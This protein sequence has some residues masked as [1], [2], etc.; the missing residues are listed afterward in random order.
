MPD[1][2][3][4]KIHDQSVRHQDHKILW[5]FREFLK[6]QK[7]W[8]FGNRWERPQYLVLSWRKTGRYVCV[9]ALDTGIGIPEKRLSPASAGCVLDTSRFIVV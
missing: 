1:V 8:F 9:K 4:H 3:T 2:W 7:L 6:S 5:A